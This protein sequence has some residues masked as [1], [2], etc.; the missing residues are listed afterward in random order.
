MADSHCQGANKD[1]RVEAGCAKCA[2][3]SHGDRKKK[4]HV[5]ESNVGGSDEKDAK[6]S[7]HVLY[8]PPTRRNGWTV[9]Q[10]GS[11]GYFP[12]GNFA[13]GSREES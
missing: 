10:P 13:R 6:V 12:E 7:D 11:G 1:E 4:K 5:P 3:F 2:A 8:L 9:R